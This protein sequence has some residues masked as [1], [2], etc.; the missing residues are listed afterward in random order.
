MISAAVLF[1][2]LSSGVVTSINAGTVPLTGGN[3]PWQVAIIVGF[4]AGFLERLV[5]DLLERSALP[6]KPAATGPATGTAGVASPS[7]AGSG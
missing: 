7:P 5:P 2:L 4:A 6:S 3:I 1:L